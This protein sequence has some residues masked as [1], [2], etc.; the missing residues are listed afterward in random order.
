VLGEGPDP[1]QGKGQFLRGDLQAHCKASGV[2]LISIGGDSSDAA[3][4][5][6]V[7]QQLAIQ[8]D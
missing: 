3:F 4:R 6:H 7:L 1:P 5:C 8:Y 2:R